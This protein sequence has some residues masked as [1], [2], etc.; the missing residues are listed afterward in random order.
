M[1]LTNSLSLNLTVG[2]VNKVLIGDQP[3]LRGK[4]I[5]AIITRVGQAG[6]KTSDGAAVA[7]NLT[8]AFLSL[9]TAGGE[10]LHDNLP[11]QLLDP[12]RNNGVVREFAPAAFDWNKC[13]VVYPGRVPTDTGKQIPLVFIYE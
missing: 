7:E 1:N 9:V 5:R 10:V 8:N 3:Q 2:T 4:K 11:L 13:A 6:D 12:A